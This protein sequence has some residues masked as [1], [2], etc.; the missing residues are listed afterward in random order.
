MAEPALR[1]MTLTE[2]LDW[3]DG[4]DTRYELIDGTPV[5][6]ASP[7]RAHGV[8]A[9]NLAAELR[10]T[11]RSRS[12]CVAQSEAGIAHPER[13]DS[14]YVADL[15]VTCAPFKADEQIA[16]DPLLIVEILSATTASFDRQAKV[17]AYRHIASVAE[18]LLI[19]SRSL[20]AE[21]LRRDGERWITEIVQGAAAVL[22]LAS[23]GLAVRMAD[24]YQGTGV[25]ELEAS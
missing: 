7:R 11:L 9:V 2:F 14:F 20:F 17:A 16:R 19:D 22:S 23:V 4:T 8:L 6:M 18:I 13:D 24:L 12:P 25:A 5:A 10:A 1:R 15:A 21:V 3:E